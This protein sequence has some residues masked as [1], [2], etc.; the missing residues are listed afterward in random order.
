M[1]MSCRE[2]DLLRTTPQVAGGPWSIDDDDGRFQV[3]REALGANPPQPD[4]DKGGLT[5][6]RR[7]VTVWHSRR[8]ADYPLSFFLQGAFII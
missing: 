5:E 4:G 6:A 8:R 1:V 2:A 3:G 7:R